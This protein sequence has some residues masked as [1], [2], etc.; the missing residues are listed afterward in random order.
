MRIAICDDNERELRHLTELIAEYQADRQKSVDCRMYG[1]GTDFLCEMRDGEY[2]LVLMD[3]LMPGVSGIQAAR[4]MRKR[5]KDVRI[6]LLSA[7]PEFAVESY[8]VGAYH[9]LLKPVDASLLFQLLDRVGDELGAQEGQG[10]L[11]RNREGI[12]RITYT[13]LAYVEVIN[14]TIYCHMTEG[15]THETN[16][17]LTEFEENFRDREDFVKTHRSYLVNLSCIQA[18]DANYAVTNNGSRIPVSRLRHKHVQDSFI[19]FQNRTGTAA[20]GADGKDR[21]AGGKKTAE[22]IWRILLVDDDP[23]E[24]TIWADLLRGHGCVVQTAGNGREALQLIQEEAFACVLLDVMIPG[25]DGFSICERLRKLA[26]VPVIFLSSVTETDRQVEG[27]A[28]GGTDYITKDTPGTLFWA[29]VEARIKLTGSD[30]TQLCYGPLLLDLSEHRTLL[31]GTEVALA[32][33]E[34]DILHLLSEDAGQIYTPEEVSDRIWGSGFWDG[35]QTVQTHMSRLRRKLEK[36][37][38]GHSFIEAVWGKGYR[39]VPVSE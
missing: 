35:G 7:A 1:N 31:N 21:P 5:D 26:D 30:R 6:I 13:K 29:K 15:V 3:V 14:K 33:V 39:F 22:G 10:F 36:A 25:E 2:D 27:F 38:D 8:S 19:Q 23:A 24:R 37:Y 28:A 11:L 17:A 9:Y 20:S 34:F 32:P 18:I 12:V 16:G 4:E